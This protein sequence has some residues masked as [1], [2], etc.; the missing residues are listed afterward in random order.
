MTHPARLIFRDSQSKHNKDLVT[1]LRRNLDNIIRKGHVQFTY[2]IA[3][4]G[5][6]NEL[7]AQG[8][9]KL[10][11]MIIN[12]IPFVGT[13]SI[14]EELSTRVKRSKKIAAPKDDAENI[15]DFMRNEI[16]R[17]MKKQGDG[18]TFDDDSDSDRDSFTGDLTNKIQETLAARAAAQGGNA[19]EHGNRQMP[20]N[21]STTYGN[22]VDDI[23]DRD[24]NVED[25]SDLSN[26]AD[27]E[28]LLRKM[29]MI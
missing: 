11:A 28:R 21:P 18:L 29:G 27:T 4:E 20:G 5:T 1:F 6:M 19:P 3:E 22:S 15:N 24:D 13:A 25:M 26:D 23:D 16:T 2:E 9:R 17:G 14:I 10:P 8:I 7:K 12:K